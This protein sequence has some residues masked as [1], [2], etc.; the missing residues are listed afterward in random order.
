M[1]F[2]IFLEPRCTPEPK[3]IKKIKKYTM[4]INKKEAKAQTYGT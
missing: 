2:R 1:S 4:N 3:I